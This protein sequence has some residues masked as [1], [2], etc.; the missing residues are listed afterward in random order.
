[1]PAP[2]RIATLIDLRYTTRKPTGVDK[3]VARMVR[4]LAASEGFEVSVIAP[5]N[6]LAAAGRIPEASSLAGLPARS[7]P[8]SNRTARMLWAVSPWPPIDR[9]CP[10]ADWIYSPL[11]LWAPAK[12]ARTAVTIHGAT[13]FE[14]DFPGYHSAWARF[15]RARMEW[16]FA[17]VCRRAD[18]VISVSTYL[19][20]FLIDR[21]GLDPQRSLVVGNGVDE[22][23]FAAG[24]ADR[25]AHDP[26]RILV[27]GGLNDWDGAAHV[28]AAADAI[29]KA[30]PSMRI[31]VAGNFDEARY[32]E[33]AEAYPNLRRLGYVESEKLAEMMPGY[34]ALLYLPNV[35]SF[36]LAAV[37]AMAAG[38]P[39]IACRTT[40]VPETAGDAAIY[41]D[42]RSTETIVA[43]ISRLR[44]SYSERSEW[45][46]RGK[47]RVASFTWPACVDR[48]AEALEARPWRKRGRSFA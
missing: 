5:R 40:A 31:D 30:V 10:G 21:F 22:W 17:Q 26:D 19:E 4:G 7:I 38:L 24:S 11:E 34:L 36:G 16:F 12:H 33:A 2:N 41:V 37:E 8:F 32:V 25:T 23:F 14:P 6:Q 46:A 43:A 28:L 45:V 47:A 44:D 15:E 27:V 29:R 1:M 20:A 13:Y 42:Q 35:E 9:F 18:L 39:V 48:L 3:H